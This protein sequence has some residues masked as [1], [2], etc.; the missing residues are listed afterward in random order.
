MQ[1][2]RAPS[3]TT[4]GNYE[5]SA[6]AISQGYISP[7]SVPMTVDHLGCETKRW[8]FLTGRGLSDVE[9]RKLALQARDLGQ[10][11]DRLSRPV[12]SPLHPCPSGPSASRLWP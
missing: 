6:H 2:L 7:I 5:P 4:R 12:T 3:R 9:I 1:G 8:L 10:V 11:I